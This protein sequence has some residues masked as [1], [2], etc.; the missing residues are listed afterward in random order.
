M[1][2]GTF[3]CFSH[4]CFPGS[5]GY[6]AWHIVG[7]SAWH[8][9]GEWMAGYSKSSLNI[10][11]RF[12]DFNRN[13]IRCN[14]TSLPQVNGYKQDLSFHG[15]SSMLYCNDVEWNNLI[16][17][18][19]V[20]FAGIL[21]VSVSS[22]NMGLMLIWGEQHFICVLLRIKINA[23]QV[24]NTVS[25]EHTYHELVCMC[26]LILL[27]LPLQH[28]RYD[29]CYYYHFHHH[30]HYHYYYYHCYLAIYHHYYCSL[31]L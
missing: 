2:T 26:L 25:Q 16:W 21:S 30:Y 6:S 15:I 1:K 13:K 10:V 22:Y 9:V 4:I 5:M 20:L 19:A 29:Y 31:L 27:P 18:P 7:Y 17:G 12:C 24:P 23:Y 3:H 14:K 28:Y 11:G 8:I